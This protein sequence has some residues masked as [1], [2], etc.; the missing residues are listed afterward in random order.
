MRVSSRGTT[1]RV[2][3]ERERVEHGLCRDVVNGE[4]DVA[5]DEISVSIQL[6]MHGFELRAGRA[7][8]VPHRL[9]LALRRLEEDDVLTNYLYYINTIFYWHA[10]SRTHGAGC[11]RPPG[12]RQPGCQ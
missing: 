6:F 12:R 8:D 2:G 3:T 11:P 4:D 9:V 10:Y 1:R 7:L 5:G